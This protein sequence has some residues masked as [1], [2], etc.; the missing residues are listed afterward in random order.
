MKGVVFNGLLIDIRDR[1]RLVFTE[2]EIKMLKLE[3]DWVPDKLYGDVLDQLGKI[4]LFKSNR[5]VPNDV[6][7]AADRAAD[8]AWD[9]GE[10]SKME[11]DR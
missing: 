2:E 3:L 4:S 7:V 8:E 5:L 6:I 9:R 1:F 10:R 11:G